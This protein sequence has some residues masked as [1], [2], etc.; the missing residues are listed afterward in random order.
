[1]TAE[2]S[3]ST[4]TLDQPKFFLL[5]ISTVFR[6]VIEDC[7]K[8]LMHDTSSV[9]GAWGLIDA[10]PV[11]GDPTEDSMDL[12]FILTPESYYIAR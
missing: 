7:K 4:V 10:D 1:M 5:P 3:D 2:S 9:I 8:M 12:V 6:T 11:T